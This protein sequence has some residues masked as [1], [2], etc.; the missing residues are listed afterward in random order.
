MLLEAP[1]APHTRA[2]FSYKKRRP[3]QF[4]FPHQLA[5]ATEQDF[6][7]L[8]MGYRSK[9][10]FRLVQQMKDGNLECFLSR[11]SLL[12]GQELQKTLCS[13]YGVGP[14]V[15]DCIALFALHRLGPVSGGNSHFQAVLSQYYP[16]GFP[17]ER[18]AGFQGVMQQHLFY[19]HRLGVL[20]SQQPA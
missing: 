6:A 15:A 7:A 16:L 11:L 9:Y 12:K 10:L 4:P 1:L 19:C 13:L 3:F 18:Y 14:K 20:E 2:S 5:N 8:G 17:E